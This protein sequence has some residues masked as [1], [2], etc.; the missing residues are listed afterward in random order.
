MGDKGRQAG[1]SGRS[2]CPNSCGIA[3]SLRSPWDFQPLEGV[4]Q[5]DIDKVDA[6]AAGRI[7]WKRGD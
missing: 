5:G 4:D 7:K 1:S 3:R 2:C 6:A